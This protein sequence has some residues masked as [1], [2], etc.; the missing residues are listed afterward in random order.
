MKEYIFQS[1]N[2][3]K[4]LILMLVLFVLFFGIFFGLLFLK[5]IFNIYIILI[6]SLGTPILVFRLNKE[7]IKDNCIAKLSEKYTEIE[8]EG[9]LSVIKFEE[10]KTYKVAAYNNSTLLNIRL[11]SGEKFNFGTGSNL[12]E[13]KVFEEYCDD[14]ETA[15][16][17][18]K[19]YYGAEVEREKLFFE[20]SWFLSV[21]ML[22][23]I[24][25]VVLVANVVLIKD[26]DFKVSLMFKASAFLF[27]L[28]GGYLTTKR[29][30]KIKSNQ[31]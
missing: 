18:Y 26:G 27:A 3:K 31:L 4:A 5:N 8:R 15:I 17:S 19:N 12:K 25:T 7:K 11:K 16:E 24:V 13:S 30:R 22:I 1:A 10:I 21:L 28:W 23:T 29:K 2:K 6:V 14:L 9:E 20:R